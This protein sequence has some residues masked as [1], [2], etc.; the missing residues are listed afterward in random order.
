MESFRAINYM[1]DEA[2]AA[3][4][5]HC[6]KLRKVDVNLAD[7]ALGYLKGGLIEL[8]KKSRLTSFKS[9]RV[10]MSDDVMDAF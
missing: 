3:L 5:N 10:I 1:E 2:F 4:A 7:C 9:A 8:I 6:P